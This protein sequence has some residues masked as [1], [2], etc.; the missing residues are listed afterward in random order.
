MPDSEVGT[1]RIISLVCLWFHPEVK[2]HMKST[3]DFQGTSYIVLISIQDSSPSPN[4]LQ[5]MR[6]GQC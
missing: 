2:E 6:H 4:V 1:T 3:D 5:A